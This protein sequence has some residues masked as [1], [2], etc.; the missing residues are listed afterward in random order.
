MTKQELTKEHHLL[1]R[2]GVTAYNLTHD[3]VFQG[4]KKLLN[5][6]LTGING[7]DYDII[8]IQ[9]EG[10][11]IWYRDFD[12]SMLKSR[13]KVVLRNGQQRVTEGV[14]IVGNSGHSIGLD[15]Y[16]DNLTS[17]GSWHFDIMEVIRD[18]VSIWKRKELAEQTTS[19]EAK[20][21]ADHEARAD[22]YKAKKD[23]GA[24]A[25]TDGAPYTAEEIEKIANTEKGCLCFMAEPFLNWFNATL[26]VQYKAK[27]SEPTKEECLCLSCSPIVFPNIRFNVCQKC[28]NKRCPHATNHEHECTGLNELGQKGSAYEDQPLPTCEESLQVEQQF[29][30]FEDI[31]RH[32]RFFDFMMQEHGL[33]LLVGEM[34]DIIY[35]ASVFLNENGAKDTPI[36]LLRS[37]PE[38]V[39]LVIVNAMSEEKKL[40]LIGA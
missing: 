12:K 24:Y 16:R 20:I 2:D 14:Y 26:K 19:M 28:G 10:K 21:Q 8:E 25:F 30:S 6:D 29:Q 9:K 37:L 34:D 39:Q 18:G 1:C 32:Q 40:N 3:V 35:E 5:E 22:E 11:T 17:F 13:D 27:L 31:S 23:A 36:E 4:V 7:A 38:S 15:G 33:T